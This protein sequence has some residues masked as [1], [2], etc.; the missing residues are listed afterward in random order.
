MDGN[1]RDSG[2]TATLSYGVVDA[3]DQATNAAV[4]GDYGSLTVN[5]DG[6]YSYVAD[7][8]AINTLHEGTY[9][10]TFTVQTT[11]EHGATSTRR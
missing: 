9:A 2:E 6:T 8:A 3:Q 7:A 11:D 4:T 1:D 10:D 5:E